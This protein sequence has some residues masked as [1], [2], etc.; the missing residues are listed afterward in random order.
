MKTVYEGIIVSKLSDF[1]LGNY[2]DIV[3][4]N[5]I[6]DSF[7]ANSLD[8]CAKH[9]ETYTARG[10]EIWKHLSKEEATEKRERLLQERNVVYQ[11]FER[12]ANSRSAAY[13]YRCSELATLANKIK[14]IFID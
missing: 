2:Y 9:L 7:L 10:C 12:A 1:E 13:L 6:V 8:G 14:K 4:E 11:Q 3:F 5:R